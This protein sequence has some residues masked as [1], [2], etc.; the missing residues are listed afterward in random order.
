VVITD[1]GVVKILDF[2]LVKSPDRTQLT[3]TGV[4]MGTLAYAAPEQIRGEHLDARSDIYALG[5]ILYQM[6]TGTC[7]F[8]APGAAATI[9]LVLNE[10]PD[11]LSQTHPDLPRALCDLVDQCISKKRR[12]RPKS[13]GEVRERLVDVLAELSPSGAARIRAEHVEREQVEKKSRWRPALITAGMVLFIALTIAL[14]ITLGPSA[15]DDPGIA[16]VGI[17]AGEDSALAAGLAEELTARMTRVAALRP[18]RWVLPQS[19]LGDH[20]VERAGDRFG[21]RH[22]VT[23]RIDLDDEQTG[24]LLTRRDPQTL[25][26]TQMGSW[27]LDQIPRFETW[28]AEAMDLELSAAELDSVTA[29]SPATTDAWL[30]Y[31]RGLGLLSSRPDSAATHF[32]EVLRTDPQCASARLGLA[33]A[34]VAEFESSADETLV[35]P[36]TVILDELMNDGRLKGEAYGLRARLSAAQDDTK[37]STEFARL[38]ALH[39]PSN[40]NYRQKQ[41]LPWLQDGAEETAEAICRE[42]VEDHPG[43]YGATEDLAYVHLMT[44]RLD[45][46]LEEYTRVVRLAP[47]YHRAHINIGY[48]HFVNGDWD[49]AIEAYETAYELERRSYAA[50]ANLG[51]LYYF[52]SQFEKA[53]DMQELALEFAVDNHVVMGNYAAALYWLPDRADDYHGALAEARRL[54]AAELEESP[55]DPILLSF[56]AA[57]YV[58]SDSAKVLELA[59]RAARLAPDDAEVVYRAAVSHEEMGHRTRAL[60]YLGSAIQLGQSMKEIEHEP[61]LVELRKDPRYE[62]LTR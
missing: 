26:V 10:V 18:R 50:I 36:G 57:Y 39:L 47:V 2:G 13:M 8:T 52:T 23:G 9:S 25:E 49:S 53:A 24:I 31:L 61:L 58:D 4:A 6:L 14:G 20:D 60:A 46:A 27:T 29:A 38:A 59:E 56:L 30:H 44:G 55:D 51:S 42:A 21:L 7:P 11:P 5:V 62:L 28:L 33:H 35:D 19:V 45:E 17:A 32:T 41:W 37:A 48:I 12:H 54:A 40:P 3:E 34:L 1:D 16:V 22:L 43:Y 15:P